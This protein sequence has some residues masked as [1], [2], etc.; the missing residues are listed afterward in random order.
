MNGEVLLGPFPIHYQPILRYDE[1]L[2]TYLPAFANRRT[3]DMQSDN[4]RLM[5]QTA[6]NSILEANG[7]A[8]RDKSDSRLTPKI[9]EETRR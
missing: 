5:P 2:K 4:P 9:A 8:G 1:G 6:S 7:I 3:E